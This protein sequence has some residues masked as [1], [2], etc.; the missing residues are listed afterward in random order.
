MLGYL[1][2]IF[3]KI[4]ITVVSRIHSGYNITKMWGLNVTQV[5][6][7]ITNVWYASSTL[8]YYLIVAYTHFTHIT[9]FIFKLG[10]TVL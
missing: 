5:K 9:V 2:Y 1:Q 10:L 7:G 3:V 4:F 8:L 6:G